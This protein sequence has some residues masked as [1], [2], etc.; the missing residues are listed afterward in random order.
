DGGP[1]AP[2]HPRPEPRRDGEIR[3]EGPWQTWDPRAGCRRGDSRAEPGATQAD[4]A[5][6][7]HASPVPRPRTRVELIPPLHTQGAREVLR[8][9][10][11]VRLDQ[12]LRALRIQLVDEIR[13]VHGTAV[14]VPHDD[15]VRTIVESDAAA[16]GEDAL[17]LVDQ[18]TV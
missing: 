18:R 6:E 8:R 12:H 7:V 13:R 17:H 15:G 10:D 14:D 3:Q 2:A 4:G 9:F 1:R 5:R 11:D 16:V